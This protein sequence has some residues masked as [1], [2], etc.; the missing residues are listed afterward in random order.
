MSLNNN[1]LLHKNTN[2]N[3]LYAQYTMIIKMLPDLKK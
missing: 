2:F 1:N 3:K